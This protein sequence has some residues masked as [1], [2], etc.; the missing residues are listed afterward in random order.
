MTESRQG[1]EYEITEG[2]ERDGSGLALYEVRLWTSTKRKLDGDGAH[3]IDGVPTDLVNNFKMQIRTGHQRVVTMPGDRDEP[4]GY[5]RHV[6]GLAVPQRFDDEELVAFLTANGLPLSGYTPFMFAN[7]AGDLEPLNGMWQHEEHT[8][9]LLGQA[10]ANIENYVDV[11]IEKSWDADRR[12]T[13]LNLQVGASAD[14]ADERVSDGVMDLTRTTL[15]HGVFL[16]SQHIGY[17][18]TAVSGMSGATVS[19]ATLTYLPT[20]TDD[21]SFFGDMFAHDAEAP[22]TFT[23]TGSDITDR[24]RTTAT[25]EADGE[26]FGNWTDNVEATFEGDGVTTIADILQELADSYDPSAIVLMYIHTSGLGERICDSYDGATEDAPKLDI[27][28]DGGGAVL[29]PRSHIIQQSVV[30]AAYH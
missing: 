23:T 18:F 30:R 16:T 12:G 11:A 28:H 20:A 19:A 2:G 15:R 5:V 24:T 3:V 26:D 7:Y 22:G 10:E 21:A 1:W 14:D 17:R 8:V 13:T 27:T 25:S 29:A 9:P 4:D 6:S